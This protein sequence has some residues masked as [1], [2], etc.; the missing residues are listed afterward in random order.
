M[1]VSGFIRK[2]ASVVDI[3]TDHGYLPVYLAQTGLANSIIASDIS[4]GSLNSARRSAAKYGMSDKITFVTAPGL[5]GVS[6]KEADTVVI[7]GLG[8][9]TIA[10]ILK[11]APWTKH[12]GVSL[13]L[14]PQSKI[15]ELCSFLRK[16][17]Y[18]LLD[19]QLSRDSNRFYVIMPVAGGK[20]DSTLS[21]EFELYARLMYRRDPLFPRY[22]DDLAE[23]TRR[24]LNGMKKSGAPGFM[25]HA[26]T[27]YKLAAYT[28]LKEEFENANRK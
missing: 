28:G 5:S 1:A 3:G 25:E 10:G 4:A 22:M 2:G 26:K 19:A 16:S 24:A 13:I 21:P 27:A 20:S 7:A 14:Q 15:V 23:K 17:G 9:E 12:R 6:E 8:G 18:S 11:D